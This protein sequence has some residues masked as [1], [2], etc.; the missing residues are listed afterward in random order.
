MANGLNF[1]LFKNPPTPLAPGNLKIP[2]FSDT[3][4]TQKIAQALRCLQNSKEISIP[5][6]RKSGKKLKQFTTSEKVT[7]ILLNCRHFESLD[8]FKGSG[9][10]AFKK[11]WKFLQKFRDFL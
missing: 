10:L 8:F 6:F 3:R 9:L 2:Q 1:L 11:S 7:N 4:Q 5:G